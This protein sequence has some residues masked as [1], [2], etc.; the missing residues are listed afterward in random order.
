MFRHSFGITVPA[1]TDPE[2][3]ILSFSYEQGQYIKSYPLHHSQQIV[4]ENEEEIK[5]KLYI[6]ITHEFVMELLSYGEEVKIVSP[7][8]LRNDIVQIYKRA[9]EKNE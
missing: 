6:H 2:E 7:E 5:L 8:K 4:I 1:E 9:I 3:V